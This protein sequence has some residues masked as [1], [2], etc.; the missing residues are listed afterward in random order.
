MGS[1]G[2]VWRWVVVLALAWLWPAGAAVAAP[3]PVLVAT[4]IAPAA[5]IAADPDV[6]QLFREPQRFDCATRQT[7][8]GPGDFWILS[9]PLPRIDDLDLTV[10]TASLWQQW[11]TLYVLDDDG[12]VERWVADSRALTRHIDLGAMVDWP[13]GGK[14]RPVRLLW[15]VEGSTNLRGVLSGAQL[16]THQAVDRSNLKYGALYAAFAGLCLALLVYHSALWG[17]TR[18][19]FQLSYCLLLAALCGYALSSSG[20]LAWWWP[21]IDNNDR[22]RLNYVGLALSAVAALGFARYYFEEHVFRGRLQWMALAI[23]VAMLVSSGGILLF[24]PRMV[25]FFDG[26]YLAAFAGLLLFAPYAVWRAWRLRSAYRWV[27][28]ICWSAPI[29]V[30]VVRLASGLGWIGWS[31]LVDN[32][33]LLAMTLEAGLSSLAIAYRIHL[34]SRERDQARAHEIAARMLADT[35]PLTGLLNR[36]A[37]LDEAI[38]RPGEQA[39]WILDIDHFKRVNETIG[40]DGGDE[41]LRVFARTLTAALPAEALIARLGGEEFAV[42][43]SI[44]QG[45][46]ADVLIDAIRAARMPFDL[47]VTASMGTCVGPLATEP[48]WK[49]LYRAADRALFDA[50]AAGRDRV[51]RAPARPARAAA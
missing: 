11:T 26:L 14:S 12:R 51:R 24:A 46:H 31:V 6:L 49:M 2:A 28:A 45:R 44:E 43:V 38:G 20:A 30:G 8:F 18:H 9:A 39:L 16:L 42:V 13:V 22:L 15:H 37:F 34:L 10:R 35:D 7:R 29:S 25:R 50:K 33:T 3:A 32:S 47:T 4:C 5:A 21:G 27:F 41:V 40:H 48:D 1:I 36:R 17:A 23:V 19:R